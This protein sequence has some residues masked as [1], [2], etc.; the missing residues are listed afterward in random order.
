MLTFD[1]EKHVYFWNGARVPNVTR[2]IAPLSDYSKVD[3][4]ALERARQQGVA[5]HKMVELDCKGDLD[6]LPDWMAG[7]YRAWEKFK[8]EVGL[9]LWRSEH[10]MF[11][12]RH[13]YAGTPDLTGVLLKAKK[14]LNGPALIDIKRSFYAGRAIG[15]QT[16]AYLD[17]W[18]TTEG[19]DLRI[20]P[21]HRFAL[22]LRHNGEYRLEH[23]GDRDDFAVFLAYLQIHRWKEKES[24]GRT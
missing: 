9:E 3:P 18:N 10:K 5:V 21:S 7:H 22:Q 23:Y 14:P 6:S 8:A 4:E 11:H 19:K 15:V 1:P 16:A 24:N 20:D 17:T 12:P 2:I 13:G